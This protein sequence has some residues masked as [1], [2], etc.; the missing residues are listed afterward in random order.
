[1]KDKDKDGLLYRDR[2]VPKGMARVTC[3]APPHTLRR[4]EIEASIKDLL[5]EIHSIRVR[6]SGYQHGLLTV[7]WW[8]PNRSRFTAFFTENRDFRIGVTQRFLSL[9]KYHVGLFI[10]DLDSD[11]DEE[12]EEF[13]TMFIDLKLRTLEELDGLNTQ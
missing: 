1:M 4:L 11:N 3:F 5:E 10:T 13:K 2:M 6:Y 8:S 12:F 7:D 9:R